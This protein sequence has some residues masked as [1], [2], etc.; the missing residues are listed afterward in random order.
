MFDESHF[1]NGAGAAKRL[2]IA[3]SVAPTDIATLIAA[4]L[5]DPAEQ[6]A[7]GQ[8]PAP[9]GTPEWPWSEQSL[10]SR[11]REARALLALRQAAMK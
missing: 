8:G 2:Q 6:E 11:L 7:A 10:Q 1:Q 4:A 3:H 9:G 5:P